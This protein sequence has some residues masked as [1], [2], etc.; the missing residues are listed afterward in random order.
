MFAEDGFGE[1]VQRSERIEGA[2]G[3]TGRGGRV[4][5]RGGR[6]AVVGLEGGNRGGSRGNGLDGHAICR[7]LVEI[8]RDGTLRHGG[9]GRSRG[10][11]STGDNTH[12]G[13]ASE[14]GE[15]CRDR[16]Q[17]DGGEDEKRQ[18]RGERERQRGGEGR[19]KIAKI[20]GESRLEDRP[21]QCER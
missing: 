10:I 13:Y 8:M 2:I 21:R 7:I 4:G 3:R 6:N 1:L 19:K 18:I 14:E 17:V 11:G 9:I 5:R 15:T 16:S 12:R 20:G